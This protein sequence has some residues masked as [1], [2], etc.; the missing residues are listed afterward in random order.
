M[1]N[2]PTHLTFLIGKSVRFNNE[3]TAGAELIP[4]H[5]I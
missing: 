4:Q 1:Q 5:I 2:W 3:T